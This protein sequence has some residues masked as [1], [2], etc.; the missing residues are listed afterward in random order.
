MVL[1][2]SITPFLYR[3]Y[4]V[5]FHWRAK[6]VHVS[7]EKVELGPSVNMFVYEL[8]FDVWH[9]IPDGEAFAPE[10]IRPPAEK[11]APK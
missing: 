1:V 6:C 8:P 2:L 4:F 7:F 3:S 5:P 9:K 11:S 10:I